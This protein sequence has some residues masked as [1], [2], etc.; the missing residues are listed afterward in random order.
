MHISAHLINARNAHSTTVANNGH[1]QELAAAK[2][3][4]PGSSING[5]EL[6]CLALATCHC[7]DLY[8][9]AERRGITLH[10]VEVEVTS[11]FQGRGAPA[12]GISYR[13][14]IQGNVPEAEL[15]GQLEE[16]DEVAE[17]Q[18][19][20]RQECPVRFVGVWQ[21]PDGSI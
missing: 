13:P 3:L 21:D 15:A 8:W 10:R 17:I 9:N 2:S 5:G 11:E 1:K 18:N 6:L 20:L 7:N 16:T 12:A 19:A 14:R 4:G